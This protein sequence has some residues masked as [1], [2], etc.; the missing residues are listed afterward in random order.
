MMVQLGS[1]GLRSAS[2]A[3]L[4]AALVAA[5]LRPVAAQDLSGQPIRLMVGGPAGGATDVMARLVAHRISESLNAHVDVE[6]RPGDDAVPALRELSAAPADGHT[7][8][9]MSTG[10]LIAQS[11]HPDYPFDLAALTAVTEVASGPLI[12][13]TRNSFPV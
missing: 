12:L 8:L 13:T 3:L 9:L 10:T 4:V 2:T 1:A 7:L 6:N 5:A 11:L